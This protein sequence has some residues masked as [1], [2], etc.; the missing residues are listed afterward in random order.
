MKSMIAT[1]AMLTGLICMAPVIAQ[2]RPNFS[3]TW[4]RVQPSTGSP[5]PT[6]PPED[7]PDAQAP[8][9]LVIEQSPATI[10]VNRQRPDG[11]NDTVTYAFDATRAAIP[12]T[13]AATR[14]P[15]DPPAETGTAGSIANGGIAAASTS[16]VP[17]SAE[18]SW[19]DGA[20]TL[21][22]V[23]SV[24]GKTV[25]ARQ[26]LSLSPD[27]RELSVSTGVA[28]QHGYE[29][30]AASNSKKEVYVKQ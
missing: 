22:T 10:R 17:T 14:G 16:T 3:G 26:E 9:R 15:V 25:T 12:T 30:G 27:G 23:M 2:D 18:A 13:P 19:R 11:E 1:T 21:M 7:T 24:N 29:T 20:L 8:S 6:S 4:V 5:V 28:V